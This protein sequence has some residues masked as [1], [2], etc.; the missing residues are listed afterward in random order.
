MAARLP[1]LPTDSRR[2]PAAAALDAHERWAVPL[3]RSHTPQ[4]PTANAHNRQHPKTQHDGIGRRFGNRRVA[5]SQARDT[6]IT[7]GFTGRD[8]YPFKRFSP[9][10]VAPKKQCIRTAIKITRE[11]TTVIELERKLS[12]KSFV[13]FVHEEKAAAKGIWPSF[14]KRYLHGSAICRRQE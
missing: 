2:I 14:E 13:I 10:L 9:I 8:P 12:L 7:V 4:T 6:D 11:G 1:A 3:A 5:D